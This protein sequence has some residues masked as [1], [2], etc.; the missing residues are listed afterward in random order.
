MRI[1]LF[2]MVAIAYLL[3]ASGPTF[4]CPNGY[5]ACGSHFCCPR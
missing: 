1:A 2:T 4:A 3:A 5:A